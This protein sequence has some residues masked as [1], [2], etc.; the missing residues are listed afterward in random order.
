VKLIEPNAA[1]NTGM[2]IEI[3]KYLIELSR[4]KTA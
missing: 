2:R 3:G 4:N 1:I